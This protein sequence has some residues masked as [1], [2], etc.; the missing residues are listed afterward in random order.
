MSKHVEPTTTQQRSSE[1]TA[2]E[3]SSDEPLP[4]DQAPLDQ[5]T[6]SK[7]GAK[8]SA[9]MAAGTLV[10][11]VLG[12][13]RTALIGVALGAGLAADVFESANTI[14]NIIYML[15]AGGI[16]NV[17]LVPQI[18]K[19]ARGPDR[20]ADYT[21]RLITLT[22]IIMLGF[23]VL[24]T[25]CS[26]PI[27]SGLTL[28][29]SEPKL[30]M[31]TAFA[32][33][34]LPQIFFYGVYAILGQVLNAH[35]RFG[36]YMWAPVANN[37]V[38][39]AFLLF[40]IMVFG[41]Y[42]GMTDAETLDQWTPLHTAV[43][44]GGH[45]VGIVVQAVV[46]LWPLKKLRLNL[47]PKFGWRGMGLRAT[48]KIAGFT[49][50]TMVVSNLGNLFGSRLVTGATEARS[51]VGESAVEAAAVPGM[52]AMNVSQLI[53]VLPHS[54]FVLSIATVLF[55]RLARAMQDGD[56][57]Q[58]KELTS[59]GLRT[60]AVPM[61]LSMMVVIVLAGPLGRIFTGSSETAQASAAGIGQILILLAIGMPFRSVHFYLLRV[62]YAAENARTPMMIQ[63]SAALIT[64][65]IAYGLAPIIPNESMAYLLALIYTMVHVIQFLLCHFMVKRTFGNYGSQAVFT[66]YIRTG[67]SA[68]ASGA[69]GVFTLWLLGGYSYGFA[70]SS[71]VGALV[72]CC[73]VGMVMVIVYLVFCRIFSV[74]EV[75]DFLNPLLNRLGVKKK[76]V[77]SKSDVTGDQKPAQT[78]RGSDPPDY[79]RK[80]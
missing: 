51:E 69:A 52:Y 65:A 31:G 77:P 57:L 36:A 15:L 74:H 53:T 33:W 76:F 37:V 11:R 56:K 47:R 17:V 63:C 21:S 66:T 49:L 20:G 26:R 46:L 50:I 22:V 61:M 48:G 42:S 12:F 4:Q 40:Y 55:N 3:A 5:S 62:F 43:L 1:S 80:H 58:A 78:L 38:A 71:I 16:F 67:F 10:S 45:T 19:A 70:W 60:F 29:W 44:A 34:T 54:V 6:D 25:L 72:S 18:I 64:L 23:T 2:Q 24:I 35:G 27:M 32:L 79:R 39:I 59:S 13:I 28:D 14:P 75:G 9:I 68:I 41:Q 30:A 8:A 7:A 73:V